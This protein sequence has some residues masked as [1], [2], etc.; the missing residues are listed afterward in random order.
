[1]KASC[2]FDHLLFPSH[3][4][5]NY[6]D[7]YRLILMRSNRLPKCW[8]SLYLVATEY[9]FGSTCYCLLWF[10]VWRYII[11][12]YIYYLFIITVHVKIIMLMGTWSD[13]PGKQ[14]YHKGSMGCPW[15]I[16]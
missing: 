7:L 11:H 4:L 5:V 1:L 14:C 13:H 3:V 10:W 12:D 16:N 15:L 6:N 8:L 2:A 9:F